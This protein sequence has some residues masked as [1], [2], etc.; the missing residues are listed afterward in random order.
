MVNFYDTRLRDCDW[1]KIRLDESGCWLW[2]G[3]RLVT[4]YGSVGV[5]GR[6]D[7]S[8]SAHRYVYTRL[9]GEI[10]AGL[11]IDHLCRVRCCVNPEHLEPVTQQEN[12]RRAASFKASNRTH[13]RNGHEATP[14]NTITRNHNGKPVRWCRICDAAGKRRHRDLR[15]AMGLNKLRRPGRNA[16]ALIDAL[17][18][19]A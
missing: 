16:M 2:T 9:V 15:E 13:C 19:S 17:L 4:G 14:A 3:A 8:Q 1:Q 18:E 12:N 5:P 6:G 7:K 11:H 10:P